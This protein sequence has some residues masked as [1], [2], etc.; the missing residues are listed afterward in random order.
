VTE[1]HLYIARKRQ[2]EQVMPRKR[3]AEQ[4]MPRKRQAEQVMPLIGP[5]FLPLGPLAQMGWLVSLMV[6]SGDADLGRSRNALAAEFL[7]S[8]CSHTLLL[9]QDVSFPPEAICQLV[10]RDPDIDVV[11]GIYHQRADYGSYPVRWDHS[12][13]YL[14][15]VDPTTGEPSEDGLLDVEGVPAGFMRLSRRCLER[16]S[17]AYESGWY[18]DS[19]V[20]TGRA[21]SLFEFSV[22][23]H[24]RYSEDIFFCQRWRELGGKVWVDPKLTLT[25]HG[26]KAWTGNL[27]DW[28]RGRDAPPPPL[29]A[30]DPSK[31]AGI[32]EAA[33]KLEQSMAALQGMGEALRG[34]G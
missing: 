17:A 12:K 1:K 27:G 9:D 33:R 22:Q 28:L 20:S 34:A 8:P 18:A 21:V 14:V 2:A 11:A 4:V 25:H 30:I 24:A 19:S 3:Q 6:H 13:Q 16:M 23:N 7:A 15:A 10:G 32:E 26:E 31:L 5:N 29:L